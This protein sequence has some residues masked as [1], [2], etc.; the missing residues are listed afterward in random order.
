[1]KKA[2]AECWKAFRLVASNFQAAKSLDAALSVLLSEP[3]ELLSTENVHEP[4][5][6]DNYTM[7]ISRNGIRRFLQPIPFLTNLDNMPCYGV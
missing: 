7:I 3:F 2:L 6:R 4:Q 5:K 1:M